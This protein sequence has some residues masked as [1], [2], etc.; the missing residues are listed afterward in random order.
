MLSRV[1]G[2]ERYMMP[3]RADEME[4]LCEV[5]DRGASEE[6]VAAAARISIR[7]LYA[8]CREVLAR[9]SGRHWNLISGY[10]EA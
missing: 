2:F 7:P 3:P 6:G 8:S 5:P 1:K 4:S 9:S 10:G